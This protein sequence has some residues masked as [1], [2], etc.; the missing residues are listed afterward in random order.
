MESVEH[1][2]FGLFGGDFFFSDVPWTKVQDQV[3]A[4]RC[5]VTFLKLKFLGSFT[6]RE[7]LEGFLPEP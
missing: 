7:N 2:F 5:P 4:C 3:F 6:V 1:V